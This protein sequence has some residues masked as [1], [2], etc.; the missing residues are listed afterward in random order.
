MKRTF[1]TSKVLVL[2]ALILLGGHIPLTF[3]QGVEAESNNPCTSAQDFGAITLPFTVD[4]SLDSIPA[5]PDVDFFKFTGPPGTPVKVDL[6]GSLTG[7]G[8]LG[9]PFLGFFDSACNLIATNDDFNFK[10]N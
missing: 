3:A 6:E 8:T 4:G 9:D 1:I 7:K 5:S 10:L 2:V